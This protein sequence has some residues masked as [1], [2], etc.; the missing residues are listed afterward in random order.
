MNGPDLAPNAPEETRR[1]ALRLLLGFVAFS[2]ALPG[3]WAT[4]APHTFSTSFPLGARGWVA[5]LGPNSPHLV[6]DVGAFYLAFALLFAWAAWRPDRALVVP[7]I[8]A[9]TLFSVLHLVW[10]LRNLDPLDT[11]DAVGQTITL[12]LV[13][14][15][16]LVVLGLLPERRPAREGA[17]RV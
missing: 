12:G 2:A 14:V 15:L 4:V 3:V 6:T 7:L 9:W 1:L 16:P 13:L 11:A 10:H 5:A 17:R 8:L